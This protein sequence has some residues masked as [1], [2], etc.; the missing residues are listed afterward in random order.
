MTLRRLADYIGVEQPTHSFRRRAGGLR[1]G[2]TS[3]ALMG[4]AFS[5]A[6]QFSLAGSRRKIK[7]SSSASKCA[8]KYSPGEAGARPDGTVSRRLAS[9][10]TIIVGLSHQPGMASSPESHSPVVGGVQRARRKTSW[11]GRVVPGL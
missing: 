7:V 11:T 8:S 5:T 9:R 10:V 2:G 3:S 6:S 1:L 4:Q